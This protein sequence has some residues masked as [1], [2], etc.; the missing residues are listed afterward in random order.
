MYS[1]ASPHSVCFSSVSEQEIWKCAEGE[2][3]HLLPI[4]ILI[5]LP[6]HLPIIQN[7]RFQF[8]FKHAEAIQKWKCVS[9]GDCASWSASYT[10]VV[11]KCGQW[12]KVNTIRNPKSQILNGGPV[13]THAHAFRHAIVSRQCRRP[14]AMSTFRNPKSFFPHPNAM[15]LLICRAARAPPSDL[16]RPWQRVK[17]RVFSGGAQ[18][19]SVGAGNGYSPLNSKSMQERWVV[20]DFLGER[21]S[22]LSSNT[23]KE[24]LNQKE[25]LKIYIK[26]RHSK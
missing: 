25:L 18:F 4:P 21:S 15:R 8:A 14:Q 2:E 5:P 23:R 13:S 6:L 12:D 24:F 9:M 20:Q 7:F 22:K 11:C 17:R 10:Y 16:R 3:G 19:S 26:T 1:S